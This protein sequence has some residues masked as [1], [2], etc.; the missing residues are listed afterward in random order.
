MSLDILFVAWNR[1]EF[2]KLTFHNLVE[3]TDLSEVTRL[4]VIDDGSTDGTR[5]WLREAVANVDD[6]VE[7]K[8][9]ESK[10]GSPVA[11]M[12]QYLA[13]RPAQWFVKIDNDIVVCPGW[14]DVVLGV[15]NENPRAS[16][17]GFEAGMTRVVGRGP[18]YGDEPWDGVYGFQQ[19]SHIGGIGLMKRA[20]FGHGKLRANGR[21]FGFTEWQAH[22]H[23]VERGW[24]TPDLACPLLDRLPVEPIASLSRQYVATNWQRAWPTYDPVFMAWSWEWLLPQLEAMKE[25]G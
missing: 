22:A 4:V 14:L 7:V 23:G 20:A 19:S 6:K 12:A 24:V 25:D 2:T 3:N 1:L 5:E 21:Y 18:G 15:S 13:D 11:V 10:L 16:L 8:L 9:V 17:I